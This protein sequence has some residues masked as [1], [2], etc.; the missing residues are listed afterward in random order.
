MA[1]LVGEQKPNGAFGSDADLPGANANSTGAAAYALLLAGE[2]EPAAKAAAWLRAHQLSNVANCVYYDAADTGAVAYDTTAL[3]AAQGGPMDAALND[4]TIR[5]TAEA[6]PGLV[7]AQTGPGEPHALFTAEY[8]KAGGSKPVGVIDAAPGE[9]LCAMLGEQ[10]VL[11]YAKPNGEGTLRVE[12][13]A[14]TATSKVRVANA[15]GTFGTVEINALGKKKLDVRVA[16]K[17][18]A[19][20]ARQAVVIRG[21]AP[22]EFASGH[23]T[24]VSGSH[25]A[26]ASGFAGQANKRGVFRAFLEVDG[27]RGV[28]QVK[29][30]GA[31]KNRRGATQFTVTR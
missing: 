26:S 22:G 3:K 30:T 14:R 25:D 28:V 9:A 19:V 12:I 4:Q 16:K 17:R 13:P 5:A 24:W 18:V 10:S 2:D 6:L 27:H 20:G 21:L 29:A 1:W 8:V 11:G 23:I 15:D 31:F 7:A